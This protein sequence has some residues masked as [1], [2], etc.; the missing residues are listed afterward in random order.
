L[1]QARTVSMDA[2]IAKLFVSESL[3]KT[4]LG[5]EQ[6]LLRHLGNAAEHHRPL[7]WTVIKLLII[8]VSLFS[9]VAST[10]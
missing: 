9:E 1:E 3:L 10:N 5:G 7:A 8:E 2:A 4:A 6:N